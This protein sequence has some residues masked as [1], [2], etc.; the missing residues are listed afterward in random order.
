MLSQL[1]KTIHSHANP[2]K[3]IILQRFFKT[4]KGE[5]AEGDIFLGLTVPLQRTIAKQFYKT[6]LNDV[7]LL[8]KNPIHECRLIALFILIK[9]FKRGDET[10][11]KTIY[12]IYLKNRD[13]I[14]NWDL[15]DTSAPHIIGEYLVG[16][17]YTTLYTFAKSSHL[18]ERRIAML[19]SFA[20][21]KRGRFDRSIK[22]A[23]M[24]RNDPHDLIQKA[25]GWM[26]REIG[27]KGGQAQ[28]DEF[29]NTYA[30]TMP[31]TMLRYAIERFPEEKRV[32]YMKMK[33]YYL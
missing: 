20:D 16:K 4:G 28:E 9:Q 19:S 32:R 6:S 31:R 21:I 23:E 1:I 14:N 22:I 3:A 33:K 18:W 12:E 2:E 25:V 17:D 11:R 5:Y 10:V 8:L 26:L 30:A 29:L 24:L 13:S 7:V 15:I 27:K